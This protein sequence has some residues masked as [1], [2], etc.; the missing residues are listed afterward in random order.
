[1]RTGKLNELER[2]CVR[3][4]GKTCLRQQ[5]EVNSAKLLQ[6][7]RGKFVHNDRKQTELKECWRNYLK[8]AEG[9]TFKENLSKLHR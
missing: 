6:F 4:Y 8:S 3:E 2:N 7:Y 5:I 9:Q 1:M